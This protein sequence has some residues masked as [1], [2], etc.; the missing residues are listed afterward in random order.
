[1]TLYLLKAVFVRKIMEY[2]ESKDLSMD[3][4]FLNVS[5]LLFFFIYFFTY[6][7]S[8]FTYKETNQLICSTLTI[9]IPKQR[10][11]GRV[12]VFIVNF[13]QVSGLV[14]V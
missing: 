9:E 5:F 12:G 6:F 10:Q 13:E 3:G 11:W 1:M 8:S 4:G 14:S 2:L 7:P